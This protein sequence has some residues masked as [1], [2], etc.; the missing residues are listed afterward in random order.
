MKL[1]SEFLHEIGH[2][3]FVLLFGGKILDIYV[4]PFWPFR[5]SWIRWSFPS[6]IGGFELSFVYAGGI[7]LCLTV[8]FCLQALLLFRDFSWIYHSCFVWLSFWTFLNG[9]GYLIL[10]GV[11]PFGDVEQ[12]MRLG[13]L[14]QAGSLTLGLFLFIVGLFLQSKI[15]F[16]L[17]SRFFSR[18]TCK[19]LVLA[20]WMQIL[21]YA[22]VLWF[23]KY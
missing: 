1:V 7:L 3:I 5:S 18:K 12:L 20:F 4:S 15:F 10:G 2:G 17:F 6:K 13:C 8:S 23:S 11:R 19:I 22:L 21:I 14:N 16:D 9:V